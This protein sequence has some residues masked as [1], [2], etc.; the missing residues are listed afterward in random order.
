MED[1]VIQ[2]LLTYKNNAQLNDIANKVSCD[3]LSPSISPWS[4]LIVASGTSTGVS[5][6][7]KHPGVRNLTSSTTQNSGYGY[8]TTSNSILLCG[9]EKTTIIFKTA[10]TI[11]GITRRLGFH[12]TI[13]QN[14]ANDGVYAEIIDG[15]ITGKTSSAGTRSAT[16]ATYTLTAST[17]YRLVIQLNSD[18]TAATFY[19]YADDSNT[20]LWSSILN[21]NVPNSVGR[22]TGHGDISTYNGTSAI[23]IGS[24]DYMD[25]VLPNARRV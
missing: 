12:D 16:T 11:T 3:F 25:I 4:T 18:A 20:L 23:T 17:W 2:K 8:N 21:T 24:I 9:G 6:S 22:E 5:G 10:S 15:V 1:N 13:D 14:D 19:L 7:L